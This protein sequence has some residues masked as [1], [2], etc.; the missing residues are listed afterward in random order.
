MGPSF[1]GSSSGQSTWPGSICFFINDL[2]GVLPEGTQTAVYA[3]DTKVFSPI[4]SVADCEQLQQALTNLHSW[5]HDNNIRFNASKCKV[6]TITCK[7]KPLLQ[8]YFLGPEKLLCV[9]EEKYQSVV[10]SD[11]LTWDSHLHLI[12]AKANKLLGLLKRSCPLLTKVAVRRSLYLAIVKPHLC[13]ATEV[14]S[15]AQKSLKVKVEQV[16]RRATRW[17]L[18]LK[19]GQMWYGERLLTLDMLPLAYDREI[20]DLVFFYK[21]VYG[22]IDVDVS[23][24]VTFNNHPRIRRGQS[25]GCYLTF[26]ACKTITLQAS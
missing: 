25:A 4:S 19:L 24:Y 14:W 12:T 3:D 7:K 26:P 9:R 10:I 13:Y 16:P 15:P 22:Y 6:L 20:K 23:D 17:I 5:S 1:I 18:S 8:D 11:K 21:A 2:P